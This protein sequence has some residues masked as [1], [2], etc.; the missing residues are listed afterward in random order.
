MASRVRIIFDEIGQK[1]TAPRRVIDR[2]RV[3]LQAYHVPEPDVMAAA[4]FPSWRKA[5]AM[6]QACKG[7]PNDRFPGT[8]WICRERRG[9][10][11]GQSEYFK[12]IKPPKKKKQTQLNPGAG[13]RVRVNPYLRPGREVPV[14]MQAEAQPAQVRPVDDFLENALDAWRQAPRPRGRQ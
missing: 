10:R 14:P 12:L 8:L 1:Y 4:G 7:I 3:Y 6:F 13:T 9:T 2:L 5:V 11:S